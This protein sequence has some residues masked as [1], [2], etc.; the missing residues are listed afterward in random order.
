MT[1][2]TFVSESDFIAPDDPHIR[3]FLSEAERVLGKRIAVRLSRDWSARRWWQRE[4]PK[5]YYVMVDLG[6]GQAQIIN[7]APRDGS[8]WSI[9]HNVPAQEVAAW[10]MGICT[11]ATALSASLRRRDAALS[12]PPP[13]AP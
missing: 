11:A 6:N 10:L 12:T 2:T 13:A 4:R 1:A 9:N 3:E 5:L 7:F 8:S